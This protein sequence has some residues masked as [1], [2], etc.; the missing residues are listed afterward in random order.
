MTTERNAE[1]VY[2]DRVFT[3]PNVLSV[4]RLI[5]VPVFLWLLL[6]EKADGWAFAL[7]VASGITDWLDG[8]L[9]RLLDQSSR[10]GA[11]LDPLV[12]R[13]YLLATLGGFLIRGIL[14]WWVVLILIARDGILTLTLGIYRRRGLPPPEVIYLGKA[15]TFAL[16]SALPWLLAGQ[17]DWA[18]AGF[19]RAFGGAFLIWGTVVYVWTGILYLGKAVAVARAIPPVPHHDHSR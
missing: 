18:A 2:S 15:A 6:V 9:A 19:G 4:L 7:L 10:L 17:M 3:V 14:P 5:G 8:K 11:L 16:M 12:D 1:P 13:L